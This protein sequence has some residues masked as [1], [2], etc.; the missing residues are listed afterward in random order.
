VRFA[1]VS[2]RSNVGSRVARRVLRCV[3]GRMRIVPAKLHDKDA[4]CLEFLA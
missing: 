4:S 3:W 1:F 2:A